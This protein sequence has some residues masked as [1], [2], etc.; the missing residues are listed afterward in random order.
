MDLGK[1]KRLEI[2]ISDFKNQIFDFFKYHNW[3]Y[4]IEQTYEHGEYL[5]AVLEKGGVK[6]KLALLYSSATNNS[7]YKKLDE[8]VDAIVIDGELYKLDSY[9]YGIKTEVLPINEIQRLILKWN[10]IASD[11]KFSLG[12]T[13]KRILKMKFFSSKI[14]SE[15]PIKQI[16]SRIKQLKSKDLAKIVIL[17]RLKNEG[18]TL[19]EFEINTKSEG[20]SYCIQNA[21]DYFD[22]ALKQNLNQ[23]IVSFYYG[24]IALAQ[25]EM[26]A[27]PSGPK[28][29][30]EV[31][32]MTKY[33]HGLFTFDSVNDNKFEGFITG[34]LSNGFYKKWV[35]FL[36]CD[37]TQ[38]LSK[39]PK[40]KEEI[41]LSKNELITLIELFSRIPELEDLYNMVT[42]SPCN[43]LY[44]GHSDFANG[45]YE[46]N[47]NKTYVN[48]NDVSGNK[49]IDD[50]AEL[51]EPF[52]QIEYVDS[53]RPGVHFKTLVTHDAKYW[54]QNVTIHSSPFTGKTV[55]FPIF[56]SV[57]E[58]RAICVAI[59]YSLSILVRYRPS[60]WRTVE[61]GEYERYLVLTEEFLDIY[62]RI[63]PQEFLEE[64]IG[65]RINV[66]QPGTLFASI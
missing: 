64:I 6:L 38:F 18:L 42:D 30:E 66:T 45:I 9:A 12:N 4:E 35:E 47:S 63:M 50:I 39:K 33:G 31:E 29:L 41:D 21:T 53:E 2:L 23:R 10:E 14:Q 5:I 11:G 59:L 15:N 57:K 8:E 3:T 52:S 36:G 51:T 48:L 37:V 28:S 7:I 26:L 62:E 17:E 49:T 19:T 61:A 32:N 20:L 25:A 16:W 34:V 44:I 40:K 43:W 46:R 54:Y 22:V 56:K 60:I 58:Y 27:S 13:P 65:K 55:L 1:A 24:G